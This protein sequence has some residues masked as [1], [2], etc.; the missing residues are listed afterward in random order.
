MPFYRCQELNGGRAQA[1]A[2]RDIG[3]G[4]RKNDKKRVYKLG[5][6]FPEDS[7]KIA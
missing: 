2:S 5:L 7:F 4:R 1:C 6:I 3:L